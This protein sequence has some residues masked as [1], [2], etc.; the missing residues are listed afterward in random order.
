[1]YKKEEKEEINDHTLPVG[2]NGPIPIP[3]DIAILSVLSG[4]GS[5]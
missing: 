4:T 2:N 3:Q 5:L 1:M